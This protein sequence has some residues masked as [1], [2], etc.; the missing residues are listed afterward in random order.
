MFLAALVAACGEG[1]PTEPTGPITALTIVGPDAVRA[2]STTRYSATGMQQ[3]GGEVAVTP[4]WTSTNPNVATIGADGSLVSRSPGSVRLEA[5]AQG[6]TSSKTIEVVP[7]VA[8]RWITSAKVRQCD[9]TGQRVSDWWPPCSPDGLEGF[10][11]DAS[12]D[13]SHHAQD[14]RRVQGDLDL[15]GIESMALGHCEPWGHGP[16]V[17]LAGNLSSDGQLTLEGVTVLSSTQ[18]R[19][20]S[21]TRLTEPGEMLGQWTLEISSAGS[22]TSWVL[23]LIRSSTKTPS[24]C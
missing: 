12:L 4:S 24:P 6:V 3:G 7:S 18:W 20:T 8:G 17:S 22:R 21:I 2:E 13:V 10:R 9:E 5:S 19:A 11:F 14:A 23:D 1:V 15:G 16:R